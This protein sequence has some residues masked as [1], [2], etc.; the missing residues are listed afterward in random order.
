MFKL[1]EN[2]STVKFEN[3]IRPKSK[4]FHEFPILQTSP[5]IVQYRVDKEAL[6]LSESL[7]PQ[8]HARQP[9]QIAHDTYHL[10]DVNLSKRIISRVR[11]CIAVTVKISLSR[12]AR[13]TSEKGASVEISRLY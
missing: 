10:L 2:P 13:E 6:N 11:V 9:S 1:A 12:G 3:F 4:Y 8:Y 5:S 7:P